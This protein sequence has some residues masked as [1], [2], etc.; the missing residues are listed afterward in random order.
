MMISCDMNI[1]FV[2][3]EKSKVLGIAM[4]ASRLLKYRAKML[5]KI[6]GC[7]CDAAHPK[8]Q[9]AIPEAR[10]REIKAKHWWQFWK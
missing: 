7:P 10:G 5:M 3:R 4:E 6:V 9:L 2:A 1:C 8:H